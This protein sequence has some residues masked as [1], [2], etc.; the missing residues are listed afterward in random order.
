MDAIR[1]F[2]YKQGEML[3]VFL[4]GLLGA[5]RL[6]NVWWL[7]RGNA[8][9]L[10]LPFYWAAHFTINRRKCCFFFQ[11]LVTSRRKC[12]PY[13]SKICWD[14]IRPFQ[15]LVTNRGNAARFSCRGSSAFQCLWLAGGNAAIFSLPM[16]CSP[17]S[18]NFGFKQEE[19][20]LV[21]FVFFAIFSWQAGGN[22][23][24]FAPIFN[25]D[26]MTSARFSR[27]V[28]AI[29]LFNERLV[30]SRRKCCQ[31]FSPNLL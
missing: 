23:A 27:K 30:T 24:H 20:L 26:A 25:W 11:C 19:M 16:G 22:A 3:P 31:F 13:Y 10:S 1:K 18:P 29:W 12:C 21:F 2:G 7:A 28:I 17:A 8:A 6:F 14:A 4:A 9:N 5:V 15:N